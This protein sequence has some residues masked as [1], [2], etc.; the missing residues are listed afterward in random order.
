[1]PQGVA[2][3][4]SPESQEP[5]CRWSSRSRSGTAVGRFLSESDVSSSPQG[6]RKRNASPQRPQPPWAGCPRARAPTCHHDQR[7]QRSLVRLRIPS[8]CRPPAAGQPAPRA[9]TF[10]VRRV[11][12]PAGVLPGATLRPLAEQASRTALGRGHGGSNARRRDRNR[13]GAQR[14]R[15]LDRDHSQEENDGEGQQRGE[16]PVESVNHRGLPTELHCRLFKA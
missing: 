8:V 13:G 15:C 3:G 1:M 2:A 11:A 5:N 9:G 7:R 6:K 16:D 12:Q 14:V 10:E 4:R